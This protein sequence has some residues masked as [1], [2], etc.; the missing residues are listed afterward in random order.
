MK[1]TLS[2][3]NAVYVR[4]DCEESVKHELADHFTY[5]AHGYKFSPKFKSGVWDGKIR[6]FNRRTQLIYRG[7][8]HKINQ[9]C[10]QH[11]YDLEYDEQFDT[12]FSVFEAKEYA[13][14]LSL[15]FEVRDYQI[16]A[17]V[18]G[19]RHGRAVMRCPTGSGKS[20]IIYLLAHKFLNLGAAKGLII[21]PTINLVN[22]LYTDLE[23]YGYDVKSFVHPVYGDLTAKGQSKETDKPITISTWQSI[24][25]MPATYFKQFEF[26]IGDECHLFKATVLQEIMQSLTNAELRIGL[27]GSLDGSNI[28]QLLL[29]GLFGPYTVI[30]ETSKLQEQK[31]L[32]DL[33]IKCIL[34]K[35]EENIRKALKS[36]TYQDELQY[37][38]LS[39]DR[40]NF[41]RNLALSLEGNT[42]V[43][44]QLVEKQGTILYD[45]IIKKANGR[46]V[47]FIH[48]G[49]EGAE[50]ERIRKEVE[51][52]KDA[53]IVASYGTFSTGVN[54]KNLHNVIFASPSKSR[55][56][57]LQSIGRVLRIADN[58]VGSVLFD[59]A[60][61]ISWKSHEN[62]TLKHFK[63]RLRIYSEEKFKFKIY[64]VNLNHKG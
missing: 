19:V 23:D 28:N 32:A 43:L 29:E 61:D 56:R 59:I 6:L 26:V 13:Q 35:H 21:V 24:K 30:T 41:I 11:E 48:G 18:H 1:V 39:N 17:F 62:T 10:Q 8:I 42:L 60:D 34:L 40:N 27:T 58:G 37:L 4:V 16:K 9:F 14:G 45:S 55:V 53:I 7:L 63:E 36:S 15:P 20:L 54:I 5:F 25:D 57:I 51:S 2:N 31:F 47:Y 3:Y 46:K 50:R 49:V 52:E 22:Q 64:N 33:T 38:V 12:D 44:Y